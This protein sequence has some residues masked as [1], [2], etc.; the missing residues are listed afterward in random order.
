M[1]RISFSDCPYCDS[2]EVYRSRRKTWGDLASLFFLLGIARCH[3]C[4]RRH[5][6]PVF[7]PAP[8]YI[9]PLSKKP[10][11]IRTD[12]DRKRSA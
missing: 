6:R 12:Q 5:F 4:M 1:H 3:S 2:T 7:L 9:P 8:E 10:I 11:P